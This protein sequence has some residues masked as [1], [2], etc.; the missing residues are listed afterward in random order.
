M[1]G[2]EERFLFLPESLLLRTFIS[3]VVPEPFFATK[4]KNLFE[5]TSTQVKQ[6]CEV[7]EKR[8]SS[9]SLYFLLQGDNQVQFK[10]G[11]LST[12]NEKVLLTQEMIYYH[13]FGFITISLLLST[14]ISLS[15]EKVDL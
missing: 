12:A 13:I 10:V 7:E 3:R 6:S 8:S 2:R 15:G 11:F 1:V 5:S 9:F 4:G 14:C